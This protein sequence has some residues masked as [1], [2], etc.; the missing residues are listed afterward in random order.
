MLTSKNGC[1][2]KMYKVRNITVGNYCTGLYTEHFK[3]S[4]FKPTI[5]FIDHL[6]LVP[7]SS[8]WIHLLKHMRTEQYMVIFNSCQ[9]FTWRFH[10]FQR[11]VH[12]ATQPHY[13]NSSDQYPRLEVPYM[14]PYVLTT[15]Y[16]VDASDFSVSI[17][18]IKKT[19]MKHR[20]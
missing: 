18:G 3:C 16:L 12:E 1:Q 17:L 8:S 19:G 6:S 15:L 10:V 9:Y 14:C 20:T 7:G 4:F 13:L 11:L 2:M 5:S